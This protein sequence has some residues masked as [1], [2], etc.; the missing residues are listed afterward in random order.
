MLDTHPDIAVRYRNMMMHK[1]GEQRL[2]MGCS[3]HETCK[4][5]VRS[6]ILD[7]SPGSTEAQMRREMFLRFYGH[8]FG[9]SESEKLF[10]HWLVQSGS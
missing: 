10:Q 6:A 5:I 7:S 1:S 9:R 3:M 4:Q 2:R 8:E